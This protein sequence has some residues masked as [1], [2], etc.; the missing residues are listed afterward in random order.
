MNANDVKAEKPL[1]IIED[2]QPQSTEQLKSKLKVGNLVVVKQQVQEVKKQEEPVI[3]VA[4][5]V[6][7]IVQEPEVH[8]RAPRKTKPKTAKEQRKVNI[9]TESEP[10]LPT[11]KKGRKVLKNILL[12]R[13]SDYMNH[14]KG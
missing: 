14:N 7:E 6:E 3:A 12:N 2:K 10:I 8:V 13:E 9:Q 1:P 11:N 4:P 5:V